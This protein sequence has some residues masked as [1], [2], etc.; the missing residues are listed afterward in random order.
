MKLIL[1]L[2]AIAALAACDMRSPQRTVGSTYYD[3]VVYIDRGTGC[4]YLATGNPYALTPR[5]DKDGTTH[6]C[7]ERDRLPPGTIIGENK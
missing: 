7:R 4:H 2:I 1:Q 3:P 6:I 5:I